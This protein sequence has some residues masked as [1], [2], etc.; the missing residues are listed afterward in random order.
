MQKKP[1]KARRAAARRRRRSSSAE[2]AKSENKVCTSYCACVRGRKSSRR[3]AGGRVCTFTWREASVRV[4]TT[5]SKDNWHWQH[6]R[7]FAHSNTKVNTNN[8]TFSSFLSLRFTGKQQW[9]VHT[10]WDLY[11]QCVCAAHSSMYKFCCVLPFVVLLLRPGAHDTSVEM[12][13]ELSRWN[14]NRNCC[15]CEN[16]YGQ[17]SF[18]K[19]KF[20]LFEKF[21]IFFTAENHNL[22]LFVPKRI[23]WLV[24]TWRRFWCGGRNE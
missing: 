5:L 12:R 10:C 19:K 4:R 15:V 8:K 22:S 14:K 16:F 20:L 18:N 7:S 6:F 3:R 21:Q 1:R 13:K 9:N 23:I 2:R 17:G 11:T 24:C